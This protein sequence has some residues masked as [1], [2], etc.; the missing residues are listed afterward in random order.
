MIR[1]FF[2]NCNISDTLNKLDPVS[3]RINFLEYEFLNGYQVKK[4]CKK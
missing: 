2:L 4:K 3:F 1:L